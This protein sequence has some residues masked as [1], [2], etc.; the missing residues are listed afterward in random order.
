MGGIEIH[1]AKWIR[2]ALGGNAAEAGTSLE[3]FH[4][5]MRSVGLIFCPLAHS[6]AGVDCACLYWDRKD[7]WDEKRADVVHCRDVRFKCYLRGL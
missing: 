6:G 5:A 3:F 2:E 1:S 4:T 7:T